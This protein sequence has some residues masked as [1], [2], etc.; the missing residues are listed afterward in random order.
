[1][2]KGPKPMTKSIPSLAI[3]II[4]GVVLT[5]GCQ[6]RLTPKTDPFY[7]AVLEQ[8]PHHEMALY[9]QG[10]I[11]LRK[12]L[13]QEAGPY[14]EKLIKLSP[15]KDTGWI[16]LGQCLL[17]MKRGRGAEIMFR[18]AMELHS[19]MKAQLGLITA[20][21]LSGNVNEAK[22]QAHEAETTY[23]VSAALLRVQGD[24]AFFEGDPERARQLYSQSLELNRSQP[25]LQDRVRDIEDYLT[26]RP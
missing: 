16:G 25:D 3:A 21:M 14:F 12:G 24:L 17:E 6:F 23:G 20:L 4:L 11:L 7:S 19:S 10:E 15:N 8:D 9:I 13:F 18:K 5:M 26:S 22:K 1:M 2:M